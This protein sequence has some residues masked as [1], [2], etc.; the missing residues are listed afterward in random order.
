MVNLFNGWDLNLDEK[1]KTGFKEEDK[2]GRKL[3]LILAKLASRLSKT[4]NL[5]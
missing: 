1:K 3:S 5:H 4:S 2:E